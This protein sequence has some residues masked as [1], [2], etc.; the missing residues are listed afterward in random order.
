ML[1]SLLHWYMDTNF[2]VEHTAT[3]L[4]GVV[5]HAGNVVSGAEER[6]LENDVRSFRTHKQQF[7]PDIALE[8]FTL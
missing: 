8:E 3:N 1:Y 5:S 2:R 4:T 6:R 7:R